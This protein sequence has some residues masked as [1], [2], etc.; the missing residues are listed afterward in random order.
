MA[1]R[2]FLAGASGVIG[3]R[4]GVLLRDAGYAVTGT[5]RSRSKAEHLKKA[6]ITPVVVDV[7]DAEALA[8]AVADAQ[9]AIVIHQLTDLP[10]GLDPARMA[11]AVARNAHIRDDGTRNLIAAANA[12]GAR[13]FIAQSIAWAYAPGPEPHDEDDPLDRAAEGMRGISVKGVAALEDQIRAAR[14][15]VL[16]YGRLYGPD[17]GVDA[18]PDIALHADAAAHAA[19]LA[20]KRGEP[21]A[22][23]IA[24]DNPHVATEKARRDLGFD[25]GFRM[26]GKA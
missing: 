14:G 26:E 8:R 23:N 13:R 24:E 1:M 12:A 17:T 21:G 18:P 9:P 16:R 6:G 7:F 4:L 5:T 3:H 19:L 11:E 25:P 20:L 15:I 22:Y 10:P 2:I